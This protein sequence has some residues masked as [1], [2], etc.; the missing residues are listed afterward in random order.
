MI[1]GIITI[2]IVTN[3]GPNRLW[4]SP[5]RGVNFVQ[6]G[7]PTFQFQA[8]SIVL[9]HFL[10][11]YNDQYKVRFQSILCFDCVRTFCSF[12]N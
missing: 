11:M 10:T 3:M 1:I 7:A 2:T 5:T 6:S 12:L 9:F 4:H 8:L